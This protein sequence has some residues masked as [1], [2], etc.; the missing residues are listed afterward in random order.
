[1]NT[2]S[3]LEEKYWEADKK[4]REVRPSSVQETSKEPFRTN[5]YEMQLR[6]AGSQEQTLSELSS[7]S[8][9]LKRYSEEMGQE[10][11][12][13]N[14]L[15]GGLQKKFDS[16]SSGFELSEE[17]LRQVL[18]KTSNSCLVWAILAL[19]VLLLVVLYF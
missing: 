6:M 13:H 10:I 14:Y 16:N 17:K 18:E 9:N 7:Y 1:M 3:E 11:S 19:T 12:A 4:L 8:S 15:L 5:S 2:L